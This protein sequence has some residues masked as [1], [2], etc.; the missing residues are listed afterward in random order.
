MQILGSGP[1]DGVNQID[2]ASYF[3]SA[4]VFVA[5]SRHETFGLLPV[6]A[7]ACGT[8]FVA[9]A[10]SGYLTTAQ[11]GY[12]GYFCNSDSETD[13]ADHIQLIL[14]LPEVKWQD[15][16]K[17]AIESVVPYNWLE[18]AHRSLAVYEKTIRKQKIRPEII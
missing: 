17:Q 1:V 7:R 11:D 16:S 8:P 3:R 4:R 9:R 12:G 14:E 10:N 6:E 5:C 13:L 18:T 15:L 2:L